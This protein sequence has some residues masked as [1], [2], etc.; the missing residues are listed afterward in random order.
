MTNRMR[1]LRDE[2][3]SGFCRG[4]RNNYY[5]WP[6]AAGEDGRGGVEVLD[7]SFCWIL[8]RADR[9]RNPPCKYHSGG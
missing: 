8:I 3:R 7:G 6:K 1:K 4:C 2:M 9:R 5:N